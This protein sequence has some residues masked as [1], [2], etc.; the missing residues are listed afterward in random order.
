MK[1]ILSLASISLTNKPNL[2]VSCVLNS[3]ESGVTTV[4]EGKDPEMDEMFQST[5][6]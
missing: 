4:E 3:N 1:E 5:P 2:P 6:A